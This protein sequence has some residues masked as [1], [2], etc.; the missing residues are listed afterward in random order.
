MTSKNKNSR[1]M[2]FVHFGNFGPD[3]PPLARNGQLLGDFRKRFL[4]GGSWED[5]PSRRVW[6]G[7]GLVEIQKWR[8]ISDL[9]YAD[10]NVK[11]SS[12][13]ASVSQKNIY[14]FRFWFINVLILS[15]GE[16]YDF[17]H[18]NCVRSTETGQNFSPLFI[19][20]LRSELTC[21]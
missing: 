13:R 6:S 7:A 14:H 3:P 16:C 15:E 5:L 2:D 11:H 4:W 1:I 10:I 9:C 21:L 19:P 8:K 17:Y 18:D 12:K 20:A